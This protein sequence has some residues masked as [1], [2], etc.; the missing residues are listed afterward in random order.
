M[1]KWY[2]ADVINTEGGM[3]NQPTPAAGT[4]K[5]GKSVDKIALAAIVFVGVIV[6]LIFAY[7]R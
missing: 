3:D 5:K 6:A 2:H 1:G 7:L 4:P